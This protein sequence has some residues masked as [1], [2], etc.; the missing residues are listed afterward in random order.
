MTLGR[1]NNLTRALRLGV[2]LVGG[3]FA[4]S[5]FIALLGAGLPRLGLSTSESM[6]LALLL[7][8]C[9]FPALVIW[10]A[11]TRYPVAFSAAIAAI[12]AALNMTAPVLAAG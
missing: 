7:G 9:L 6:T 12:A 4:T 1:D 11:A 5:G 10:A 8:F 3:Y 2:G